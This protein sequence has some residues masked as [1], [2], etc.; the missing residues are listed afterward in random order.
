MRKINLF[1][2]LNRTSGRRT[3]GISKR[4]L[5]ATLLFGLTLLLTVGAWGQEVSRNIQITGQVR[6]NENSPLIGVTIVEVGTINGVTTDLNGNYELKVA[7]NATLRYSFIGFKAT[8]RKVSESSVINVKL[9]P[10]VSGL[11]EI[12]VVGYGTQRKQDL[13]GA[14]AVVD[15]KEAQKLKSGS[16]SEMLQGQVAGVS[17]QSSGDPGSMGRINIRGIGSFSSVGPLY[18]VDGLIVNDVNH[19]NPTDIESM[20]VLKDASSTAIY[21]SR[22]ANGVI[23]VTTKKGKNGAPKLDITATLGA[24]EIAKKIKMKNTTDFLYYNELAYINAGLEWPGQ[25]EENTYL[26]NS[27]FQ[28]AIFEVGNVADL[29]L[30]Y[31]QGSDNLSFMMGGGYFSQ[32]GVLTGPFYKRYTYR[33]NT[34]GRYGIFKI[35]ENITLSSTN[36]KTTNTSTSSFTNALMMPPVLPIYDPDEP[37]GRGGFGYGTN[38]YPTYTTN[39]VAQQASVDNRVVNSRII[40]NVYLELN[41]FKLFTYKFNTGVDFWYGRTKTI[42]YAYTMRMGSAENKWDNVLDEV[43][44]QRMSLIMEHTLNFN[45]K[46][47]KHSIEALAGY[48]VED[49]QWHYL[50][51]EGYDQLVDGL[52][53]IDLVGTQNNMWGSEQEHRL[54]STL[55]RINYNYDDRYLV[56]FNIRRDGSSKFG[57]EKR[58]GVFP[59]GSIGWRVDQEEFFTPYRH[60]IDNLKIRASY[61]KIGDMQALGNYDYIADIDNSGPY[62]GFYAI[63]GPTNSETVNNGA[64]QSGSVNTTLGWETKT[65]KNLGVDFSMLKNRLYGTIELYDAISTDLL[66]NLPQSLA[67]GVSSKW[68]NYGSIDNRGIELSVGWRDKK[69]DFSYNINGNFSTV[70]NEVL[71]LGESYREAGFNNVNRTEKGRSVGDFYLIAFDGIFQSMDEVFENTTTLEDG[72]VKIIQPSAQPGD[73]RYVDYNQDGQIDLDDRQWMGSPLPK[74]EAGLNVSA[75]YKGIDFT[76]SWTSCYG[77]KI[78]N[79]QRY[80]L[81]SFNV[82]NY[83]EDVDP[84]TWDNPSTEYPRPYASSTD[85]TK[86]QCDRF[87]EDGSYLRL[88]NLQIGYTLPKTVVS[89]IGV[90]NCRVYISGQNLLTVTKYK[91]YDPE[92]IVSDVFGQGND[93]GSYPP[94]RSYNVGLQVSF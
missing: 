59:S 62:E 45:K 24:Q 27:D 50:Q 69:G 90:G 10:E 15:M 64:L 32:D 42:N 30:T 88:K 71:E 18:V 35:G 94:V 1:Y 17:I 82:D 80:S 11:D 7:S 72:S 57:P 75:E 67:T 83:P 26:P 85:N 54:V 2:D 22:G 48:T 53:Q 92:I 12:V 34:E 19:L 68:T 38:A 89:K 23:I 66:V 93:Y 13:T 16:I 21:G 4:N 25:P 6:D 52:W 60:I 70:R 61:G 55:G 91:G 51:A 47:G 8:T 84:W 74:F 56:Q 44:D 58:Y 41:L 29:N 73:V 43:R 36:Q 78:F 5:Y 3:D 39:P 81:L 49:D 37:S 33:I 20:Q 87:L 14:V 79:A 63:F 65:T 76:M 40:G 77:N 28:S 31:S 46:F 9:E 86:V